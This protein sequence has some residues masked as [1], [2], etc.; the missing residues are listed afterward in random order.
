MHCYLSS[1]CLH[2]QPLCQFATC[3]YL[4]STF[5]CFRGNPHPKFPMWGMWGSYRLKRLRCTPARQMRERTGIALRSNSPWR[6]PSR[7]SWSSRFWKPCEVP[8][9][10]EG[11]LLPPCEHT[12]S[13]NALF[14]PVEASCR[15]TFCAHNVV[16][17]SRPIKASRREGPE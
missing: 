6:L 4:T 2:R 13:F 7:G 11:A 14:Q 12:Y 5:F 16:R 1:D 10:I 8:R 3:V 15:R 9:N 17:S